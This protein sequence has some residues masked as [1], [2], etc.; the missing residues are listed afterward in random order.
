MPYT[1]VHISLHIYTYASTYLYK[2]IYIQNKKIISV[3]ISTFPIYIYYI[4][5]YFLININS[6]NKMYFLYLACGMSPK[7]VM[8]QQI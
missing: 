5:K 3:I 8:I 7:H 6:N 2:K 1:Y 4:A